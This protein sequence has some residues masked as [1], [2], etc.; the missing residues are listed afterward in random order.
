M[1]GHGVGLLNE[2]KPLIG[3]RTSIPYYYNLYWQQR[4]KYGSWVIYEHSKAVKTNTQYSTGKK[5]N[6]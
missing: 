1:C 3:Y 2:Q 6:P 5:K 4:V